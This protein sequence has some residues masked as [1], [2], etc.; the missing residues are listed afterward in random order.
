MTTSPYHLSVPPFLPT[1]RAGSRFLHPA[2]Q[3]FAETRPPPE[4]LLPPRPR[5][6]PPLPRHGALPF[7]D[8]SPD[9][10]C[11]VGTGGREDRRV[12]PTPSG[13]S[14]AFH[15]PKGHSRA[16]GNGTGGVHPR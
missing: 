8:R 16:G 2:A 13:R 5:P 3:H 14:D 1:M 10:S 7:P 11:R 4:D 9:A 15:R 6:P 12:R